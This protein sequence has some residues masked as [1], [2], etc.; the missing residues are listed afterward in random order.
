MFPKI[1]PNR[2][3]LK[4]ITFHTIVDGV[5]LK[6]RVAKKKGWPKFPLS[7]GPFVIQNSTHART[8]GNKIVTLKLGES[9]NK[10]HDPKLFL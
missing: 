5:F 9:H 10:M 8:L 7:L 6:L 4:E 2:M 3:V 1:V